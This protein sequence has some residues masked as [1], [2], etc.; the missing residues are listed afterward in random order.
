MGWLQGKRMGLCIEEEGQGT[1]R[2]Q[3]GSRVALGPG[4][5]GKHARAQR[6]PSQAAGKTH[7]LG[8]KQGN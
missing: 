7:S 3:G 6:D 2:G 5:W 8:A 4:G 1:R